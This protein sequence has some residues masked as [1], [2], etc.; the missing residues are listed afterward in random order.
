[1]F[2]LI[3]SD[4]SKKFSSGVEFQTDL[5]DEPGTG[6]TYD[7]SFFSFTI[8]IQTQ[9]VNPNVLLNQIIEICKESNYTSK[10]NKPPIIAQYINNGNYYQAYNQYQVHD[11]SD[12]EFSEAQQIFLQQNQ[13]GSNYLNQ[14]QERNQQVPQQIN[15]LNAEIKS[16]QDKN[17][18]LQ[19][20]YN[21][22]KTLVDEQK[23]LKLFDTQDELKKSLSGLQNQLLANSKGSKEQF[24]D[25]KLANEKGLDKQKELNSKVD[26]QQIAMK[27]Y[28]QQINQI[29]SSESS[30]Q[31]Q[32]GYQL[33]QIQSSIDAIKQELNE[34]N[35]GSQNMSQEINQLKEKQIKQDQSISQLQETIQRLQEEKSLSYNQKLVS[36]VNQDQEEQIDQRIQIKLEKDADEKEIENMNQLLSQLKQTAFQTTKFIASNTIKLP[37]QVISFFS[38]LKLAKKVLSVIY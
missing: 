27:K 28:E 17:I 26:Q 30:S 22:I 38:P 19:S 15:K 35:L 11:S 6:N 23:Q 31:Q 37:F 24:E 14:S 13:I 3:Q 9:I 4:I 34:Y 21:D 7:G 8:Q 33:S 25:L 1:M 5:S 32:F 12:D 29:I 2:N 16:L 18:K 10:S 20:L 36:S